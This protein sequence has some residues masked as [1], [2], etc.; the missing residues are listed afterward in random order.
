MYACDQAIQ[1]VCVL[2]FRSVNARFEANTYG[3]RCAN[4]LTIETTEWEKQ[5]WGVKEVEER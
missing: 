5:R 2:Q 1:T 4:G 3:G